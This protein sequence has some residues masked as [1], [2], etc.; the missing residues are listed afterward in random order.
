MLKTKFVLSHTYFITK[1][2]ISL[3]LREVIV[4]I[5]EFT[6]RLCRALE[7]RGISPKD[8]E[9]Y[10]EKI[11][12]SLSEDDVRAATDADIEEAADVCV[13]FLKKRNA[14]TVSLSPSMVEATQT[15]PAQVR[16]DEVEPNITSDVFYN[17]HTHEVIKPTK[18]NK[19]IGGKGI[20]MIVLITIIS[21]PLWIVAAALFIAPFIVMFAAE[22][23]VTAVFISLLA[24]GSAAGTA[25]SLTGIVYGIVKMF[26]V[27]SVGLYEI[28]FG[29][30]LVGITLIFG[31]L[32]YNGAV[33]LMP[34][35]FKKTGRLL[36]LAFSKVKP[37]IIGYARRCANL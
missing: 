20:F 13:D 23:A 1:F 28:G 21:S 33:R 14:S 18:E 15:V 36:G 19:K 5:F 29:I 3:Y 4:N 6:D 25:A 35:V 22:T 26:T 30:I 24:G 34:F 31:I 10:I 17:T 32:S 8:C 27:P 7:A 11:E 2:D 37:F 12:K 9:E 16:S